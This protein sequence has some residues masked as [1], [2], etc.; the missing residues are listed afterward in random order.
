MNLGIRKIW[1]FHMNHIFCVQLILIIYPKTLLFAYAYVYFVWYFIRM[2][3]QK[4]S[5]RG[6]VFGKEHFNAEFS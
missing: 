4:Q 1:Y 3:V 2:L 6:K 5:S